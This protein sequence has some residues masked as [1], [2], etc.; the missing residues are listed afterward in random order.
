MSSEASVEIKYV[1]E[2][3]G[4]TADRIRHLC[5]RKQ[6]PGAFQLAPG[7]RGAHWRF[8]RGK[9]LNWWAELIGDK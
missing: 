3:T 8:H 9:L 4:L 6:I 1:M 7:V 2:L 5:N